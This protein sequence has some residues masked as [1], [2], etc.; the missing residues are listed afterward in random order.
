MAGWQGDTREPSTKSNVDRGNH[1]TAFEQ[2][3]LDGARPLAAAHGRKRCVFMYHVAAD[4]LGLLSGRLRDSRSA[5]PFARGRRKL[6]LQSAGH[7]QVARLDLFRARF[8]CVRAER[9]AWRVLLRERALAAFC[10]G[11]ACS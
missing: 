6:F 2:V 5:A 3:D 10:P 8:S 9:C 1:R 11:E 7:H 4:M